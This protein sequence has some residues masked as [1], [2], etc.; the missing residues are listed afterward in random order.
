MSR[1]VIFEPVVARKG[2]RT[3]G[4]LVRVWIFSSVVSLMSLEGCPLTK[5]HR[6]ELAA[7]GSSTCMHPHVGGQHFC[8]GEGQ[9]AHV[10]LIRQFLCMCRLVPL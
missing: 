5:L 7:K 3:E 8:C 10:T 2:F 4:T 9:Q 6:A 1:D